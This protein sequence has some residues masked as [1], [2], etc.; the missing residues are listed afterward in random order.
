MTGGPLVGVRGDPGQTKVSWEAVSACWL[1]LRLWPQSSR[2]EVW[3]ARERWGRSIVCCPPQPTKCPCA[4]TV[5]L[6]EHCWK[7]MR[8]YEMIKPEKEVQAFPKGWVGM[9]ESM[10]G[11]D[12]LSE[13]QVVAPAA[14]FSSVS[15]TSH[16]SPV[17]SS[18]CRY[19]VIS[20]KNSESIFLFNL[21]RFSF[22]SFFFFFQ[23]KMS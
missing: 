5:V 18:R 4:E 7:A 12:W 19:Y 15:C 23:H 22:L 11:A 8:P 1:W 14:S 21:L 16:D 17:K 2:R 9:R 6:I 20:L 13:G 10:A 3:W